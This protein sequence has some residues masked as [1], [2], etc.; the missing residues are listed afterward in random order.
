MNS[1]RLHF[2]ALG[3]LALI[4]TACALNSSTETIPTYWEQATYIERGNYLVN[5]L[6]HCYGCHTP[7]GPDG[8]SDMSLYLSGIPAK[9]AGTKVGPSQVAGLPGPPGTRLYTQD[10]P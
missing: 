5:H 8:R 9:F 10:P 6:G 4:G 1:W 2:L 7:L 3:A